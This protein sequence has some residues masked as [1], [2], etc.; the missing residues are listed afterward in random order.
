M[1]ES[2]HNYRD[3]E[4][5]AIIMDILEHEDVRKLDQISHHG[6]SI[7]NHSLKV[8]YLSWKWGRRLHWDTRSLAR[9]GL[10]HDFFLYDWSRVSLHPDRKFYEIHKM[11]GFTHPLTALNNASERFR[12]NKVER[13]II[14]R[15]MFPLTLIPPRYKES[16]LVMIVDKIVALG[17]IPQF[18]KYS[19]HDRKGFRN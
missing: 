16:W 3:M 13:D 1:A 14:R 11:H 4:F 18:L 19:D 10:L 12:L 9:G 15:H 7:L 8:S 2:V 6:K 5:S 17:E